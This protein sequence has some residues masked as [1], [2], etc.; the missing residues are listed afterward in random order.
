MTV[1][2]C[3]IRVC[4]RGDNSN[5]EIV[6]AK[7]LNSEDTLYPVMDMTMIAL[8][9]YWLPL[10]YK[11][12][13]GSVNPECIRSCMN[14]LKLHQQYLQQMLKSEVAPEDGKDSQKTQIWDDFDFV[15]KPGEKWFNPFE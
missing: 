6:L 12:Q 2:K 5:P 7:Y 1:E 10:A 13:F 15:L 14:R 4:L 8:M 3:E 11:H 9:A